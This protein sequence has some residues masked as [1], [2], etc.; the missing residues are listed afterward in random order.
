MCL[1]NYTTEELE[2]LLECIRWGA[3]HETEIRI[4]EKPIDNIRT[5]DKWADRVVEAISDS[6]FEEETLNF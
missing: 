5:I 2:V 1:N 6:K 4:M 3:V